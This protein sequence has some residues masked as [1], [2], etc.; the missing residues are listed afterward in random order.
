M[1]R[2]AGVQRV[3]KADLVD[4]L[5]DQLANQERGHR[6]GLIPAVPYSNARPVEVIGRE[7]F[8]TI[9]S[10]GPRRRRVKSPVSTSSSVFRGP[11][12]HG[13]VKCSTSHIPHSAPTVQR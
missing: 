13:Y 4:R 7:H 1:Q 8:D 12:S 6:R 10:A 9:P 3:V 2:E 5:V 11:T